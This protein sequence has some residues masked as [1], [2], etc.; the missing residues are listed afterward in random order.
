MKFVPLNYKTIYINKVGPGEVFR[1]IDGENIG[2]I[3]M[4]VQ[5]LDRDGVIFY[6]K[7][8]DLECGDIFST[9]PAAKVTVI[10]TVL[11]EVE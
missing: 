3:G 2:N 4:R 11:T 1:I 10:K 6:I 8:N 5:R 9:F 7:L